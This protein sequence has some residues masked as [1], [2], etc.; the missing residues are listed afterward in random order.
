MSR[1][2]T[3]Q[4]LRRSLRHHAR[5]H[6]AVA[7]GVVVAAMVIGGALIVGDSV[8]DSLRLL[9]HY[10]LN[11]VDH[12]LVSHRFFREDSVVALRQQPEFADHY[13]G[14]APVLVFPASLERNADRRTRA[15]GVTLY[16]GDERLWEGALDFQ[17]TPPPTSGGVV[18]NSKLAEELRAAPG[19]EITVWVEL[20]TTIP[21]DTLLGGQEQQSSQE[22][23][24]KVDAVL[25]ADVIAG[26]FSLQPSQQF[27]KVAFVNLQAL[28]KALDLEAVEPS[29]RNPQRKLARVN[30]LFVRARDSA[31]GHGVQ[32]VESAQE[33]TRM[34]RASLTLGD[35]HLRLMPNSSGRYASLES[36]RMIL[37]DALAK[38]AEQ[39]ATEL[40]MPTSPV[41][42]YLTNEI[43]LVGDD[44]GKKFSMYSIV[45]GVPE[46]SQLAAPFGP[47]AAQTSPLG[48]DGV[49]LSEWLAEDFGIR[50]EDLKS[51]ISN[52]PGPKIRVKYHQ[53]G[54][55]GELPE[56]EQTF[57]VRGILPLDG[58]LA[59][60]PGLTPTVPGITDAK[61]FNDWKQPFPMQISRVT[62]RDDYYWA[63]YHAA[64]KA[65]FD[66]DAARGWWSSR[67]G[68]ATSLRL[69]TADGQS[70][71]Q[72]TKSFETD[73]LKALPMDSVGLSIQPVKFLGLQAASGTT[74]FSGLFIGFSFFMILS[75]LM[76]I[77][78][79]VRLGIERRASEIG[80]LSAIGFSPSR[81]GR[82]LL[83]EQFSVV[84]LGAV[85][86]IIAAVGYAGLLIYGL[87]TLWV[88]AVGTTELRLSAQPSSLAIGFAMTLVAA[89]ASAWWGL[90]GLRKLSPRELLA[91]QTELTERDE[92]RAARRGRLQRFSRRL[93]LLSV[94]IIVVVV[95]F[96]MPA[97]EAFSGLSWSTVLFFVVGM[98]TL[99]AALCAFAAWLDGDRFVS[100][101]GSG[102]IALLRLSLRNA[103]R[104][105]RRSLLSL[106]LI[107]S[108][109]FLLVAVAA[110]RRN[111]A[112]EAPNLESG[113]GGFL[114]VA[115]STTPLIHDLSTV[116]GRLKLDLP[117]DRLFDL[118]TVASFRVR[119]GENASCLN[120]YQTRLPTILSVPDDMLES[121]RFKFIGER[122]RQGHSPWN[123]LK[124]S[125]PDG[126]IPV[127]G[128]MNTLMYSLHKGIGDT[129]K[130]PD[131]TN[132]KAT[133]RIAG[134][135][136]S[137]VFQGVLLMSE[138]NFLKLFPEQAGFRYFLIG[139]RRFEK[140]GQALSK[141]EARELSDLLETGLAPY[142][143]D[144][145]SIGDR[146]AN[147]LAVQNTYLSTFQTLG[148]L[149]LLL[150]TFGLGTVMLRNVIERRAELALLRAVGFR[151]SAIRRLVL[152]ENAFLL[153]CG[154]A[155]GTGS[156][157]LAM[158]PHLLSTG[159]DVP[160]LSGAG[161]L[162]GI[163]A[164]GLLAA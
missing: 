140:D 37:E 120:L 96:G 101:L 100:I 110:G 86:G 28:Q 6:I 115:E 12:A 105:R 97:K 84:L 150:G 127:F 75:G 25:P 42:A 135:L 93:L 48:K 57:E 94:T 59:G 130:V 146:L 49:L 79:L 11:A 124:A 46:P 129:I 82:V 148:G 69:G 65:F 23:R 112:V 95:G 125:P 50:P 1:F 90:R 70:L 35:L 121:D 38:T 9:T 159:A 118:M 71:E 20:P 32:A 136:D 152:F 43:S 117:A 108:A 132:P 88:G 76:L 149:G 58:M 55:K 161:L 64:P 89:S 29:S 133:L 114:F 160:W 164:V 123:L 128:D 109:S 33:L 16:G 77:S 13:S 17:D 63:K 85:I 126:S 73:F 2:T 44:T 103:T 4:Y 81:I 111:P 41:L 106:A 142:G 87:R 52:Q 147:F 144:V 154:L 104:Q 158:L 156:A 66:L 145:E 102:Q 8:R 68:S 47:I 162:A 163:F 116:T 137:S 36:E 138:A 153:A 3:G 74:D 14:E 62:K 83:L 27:P 113:N 10:R 122:H 15:A 61:T 40:K 91:G 80:L 30:A 60:D 151:P 24:L 56:E 155:V 134:M 5:S 78:L 51:E 139:D 72:S 45:A 107:A 98:S 26:R 18:L 141:A 31:R 92:T 99:T 157:L 54:S 131:D 39:V 22:L 119:P 67:Y 7:I 19:D 21:R 53:V 34:F 143:F